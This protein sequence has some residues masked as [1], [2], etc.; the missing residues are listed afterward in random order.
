MRALALLIASAFVSMLS[1]AEFSLWVDRIEVVQ[2]TDT[3]GDQVYVFILEKSPE[4]DF[5]QYNHPSFPFSYTKESLEQ[6]KPFSVW[7]SSFVEG[8]R[9]ELIFSLFDREVMPWLPDELLGHI[10]LSMLF[11]N[12]Q[13][14][15]QWKGLS[16]D[17]EVLESDSMMT[18]RVIMQ[19]NGGK[20]IVDLRIA[21]E[22]E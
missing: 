13:L 16:S 9:Y 7:T 12:G 22:K 17:T 1:A 19:E 4:G 6:M 5:L 15:A 14:E 11:K 18:R 3:F 21:E 8:D 20:Y 10:K 2:E